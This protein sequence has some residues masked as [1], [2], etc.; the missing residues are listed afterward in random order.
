MGLAADVLPYGWWVGF[1]ID[2]P[3]AFAKIKDG[4]YA[5]FS[6]QGHAL[7]EEV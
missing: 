4:T 6:I 3:T 2:D 5:M 7:R 1:H